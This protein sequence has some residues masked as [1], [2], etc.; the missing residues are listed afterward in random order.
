MDLW[1]FGDGVPVCGWWRIWSGRHQK[2]DRV[3]LAA[4]LVDLQMVDE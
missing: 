1:I 2:E 4:L 3:V